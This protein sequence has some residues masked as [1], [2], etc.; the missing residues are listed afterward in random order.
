MI[1][2]RRC[3]STEIDAVMAFIDLHW[4]P[5][6]ILSWHRPLIDWQHGCADGSYNFLVAWRAREV[7]GVLGYIPATQYDPT[8]PDN[9]IFLALWKVKDDAGV[10]ALGIRMLKKL[11]K[12][13]TGSAIAVAKINKGA[14]PLYQSLGYELG[15]YRQ[16]FVTNPALPQRIATDCNDSI[17]YDGANPD[18]RQRS[19]ATAE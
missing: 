11:E 8:L 19:I 3:Y 17:G 4:K 15:N 10:P 2:I 6:H 14:L 12:T 9:I 16:F 7:L 18:Q 13:Y 1:D 5:G